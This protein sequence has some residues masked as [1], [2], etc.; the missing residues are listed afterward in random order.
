MSINHYA[1]RVLPFEQRL[2][3]IWAEGTFLATRW[4]EENA[5]NLYHLGTFFAEV[6][7]DPTAMRCYAPVPSPISGA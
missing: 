1:F 2:A 7:Y 5:V 6:Y 3:V 4:E